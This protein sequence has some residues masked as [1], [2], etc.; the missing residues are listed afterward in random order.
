MS[1]A[2]LFGSIGTL[3]D[4]SEL[5]RQ[6]FN[7]AFKRHELDW[8]WSRED[9]TQMLKK[10]GGRQRIEDYAQKKGTV[11]DAQVIHRDKSEIFQQLMKTTQ[12]DNIR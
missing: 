9:Y 5:Q 6:A 1:S 11:V 12:N 8:Y 10:S 2:L 7:Q 4:T 3:A